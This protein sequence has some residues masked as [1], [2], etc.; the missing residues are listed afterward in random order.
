MSLLSL[1]NTLGLGPDGWGSVLLLGALMTVVLTLAAL[2]IGAVF[3]ALIAAAKLSRWRV[4]RVFGDF[5]TTVFRGVP[6]LLVIYLFYFGGST[7]VTTV[8]QWFGAEGFVGVPPFAVGAFAVGMISGAYQAEV[9]RAAV[10]AVARGELEAARAIGMPPLTMF[11]RIL[12]PQVLRY[13]LPGI[14][15]VWQLSLKDS[16]LIS[17]TGLAELLRA[18]Q[19]AAG[20][21]HQYFLFFVVGG[22]LYLAMTGVSNRVFGRAE[23]VVGRSFKRNFARN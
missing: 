12:V 4:L 17:V 3:G 21:T 13:A 16:A 18:S 19:I 11:R 5:Y 20:S 2:A 1:F 14:G 8:G 15:N 22:L 7:L 9:Y 23:A 6:E 10:L